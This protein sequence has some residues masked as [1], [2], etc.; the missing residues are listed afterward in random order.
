M[1]V[2]LPLVGLVLLSLMF[3]VNAVVESE[4]FVST[5]QPNEPLLMY[6]NDDDSSNEFYYIKVEQNGIHSSIDEGV[7][8]ENGWVDFPDLVCTGPS[9]TIV[10]FQP[11][12][13]SVDFYK[14]SFYIAVDS[15]IAAWHLNA[16]IGL[17]GYCVS[18]DSNSITYTLTPGIH[19]LRL[20][21]REPETSLRSVKAV[22]PNGECMF[23]AP[24]SPSAQSIVLDG[25]LSD[26]T[27]EWVAVS[28]VEGE[29]QWAHGSRRDRTEATSINSGLAYNF[30]GGVHL[31]SK[32]LFRFSADNGYSDVMGNDAPYIALNELQILRGDDAYD[33]SMLTTSSVGSDAGEGLLGMFDGSTTAGQGDLHPQAE[34]PVL[35]SAASGTVSLWVTLP[36]SY[37]EVTGYRMFARYFDEW[38]KAPKNWTVYCNHVFSPTATPTSMPTMSDHHPR[39][40]CVQGE[41][42]SADIGACAPCPAGHTSSISGAVACVPCLRGWHQ[43]LTG[44]TT[45]LLAASGSYASEP[46]TANP[47][48]CPAGSFSVITGAS[49]NAT[50]IPCPAGTFQSMAGATACSL[51]CPAGTFSTPGSSNCS[52]CAPGTYSFAGAAQCMPCPAGTFSSGGG[53]PMCLPCSPGKA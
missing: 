1:E 31:C 49:S 25:G 36:T 30:E 37:A 10:E 21:S 5:L 18:D 2:I 38:G 33:L 44:Q 3:T 15:Q 14:D 34:N 32:L 26:E 43:P 46:G 8:M 39:H 35:S 50:C 40:M 53:S 20:Y 24:A 17:W 29:T 7:S 13:K 42:F 47:D 28:T 16:C 6:F 23:A 41:F 22:T 48:V 19:S 11:D 4:I 9:S 52:K 45:C 51:L 27:L 12:V